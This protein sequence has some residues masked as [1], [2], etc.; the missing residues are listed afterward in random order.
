MIQVAYDHQIFVMQRFGGVSRYICEIASRIDHTLGFQSTIFAPLHV[1]RHLQT[2]SAH[3]IGFRLPEMAGIR[4]LSNLVNTSSG[5]IYGRVKRPQIVHQTYYQRTALSDSATPLVVTVH[6]MIHEKFPDNFPPNSQV[7][8]WKRAAIDRADMIICISE[9]TRR[10]LLELSEV[11]PEKIVTVHHGFSQLE[12]GPI[13]TKGLTDR[14][15]ILYVGQRHGYKNF[16]RLLAA[17]ASSAILRNN[18]SLLAFG[19]GLFTRHEQETF[20]SFGLTEKQ[21]IHVTGDDAMLGVAYRHATA[22]AYPSL[23]EGFGLPLLEAM[24]QGCPVACS[25]S[26]SLPEIVG[27]A[28]RL[29]DPLEMEDI[30]ACLERLAESTEDR[31]QL[32]TRGEKRSQAFS[33]ERCAAETAAAYS[34]VAGRRGAR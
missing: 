29:F 11:R 9:S 13:G 2:C 4:R 8:K 18:F 14:S 19:G 1:N 26:S 33:W 20:K 24:S 30:R 23:Y 28:A 16:Q 27:D 7:R 10:D 5:G 12:K 6:D 21:L 3:R 34:Q 15:Y 31:R 32:A 17:Y 25:N 22:F